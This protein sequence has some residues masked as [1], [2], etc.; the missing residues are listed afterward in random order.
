MKT[1]A[2]LQT[3]FLPSSSKLPMPQH[4][5][6]SVNSLIGFDCNCFVQFLGTM[7]WATW[8]RWTVAISFHTLTPTVTTASTIKSKCF[9]DNE[10]L[11]TCQFESITPHFCL[12]GWKLCF[13]V[14]IYTCV[15]LS[16]SDPA[17]TAQDTWIYHLRSRSSWHTFSRVRLSTILT[18][19]NWSIN[20][21]VVRTTRTWE[22]SKQLITAAKVSLTTT[23]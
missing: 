16:L 13:P 8:L 15:Q 11:M 7:E 6:L 20:W 22:P 17:L 3:K 5:H 1:S 2:S 10:P 23:T 18:C 19:K 12:D 21:S 14:T 4:L 9:H